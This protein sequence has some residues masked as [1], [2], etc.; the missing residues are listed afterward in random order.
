MQI[1][2]KLCA[3]MLLSATPV[4][5]ETPL[6]LHDAIASAVASNPALAHAT[7]V[8]DEA[9]SAQLADRGTYDPRLE[10][11]TLAHSER[12]QPRA[13]SPL[14]QLLA[15]DTIRSSVAIVK[16]DEDGSE[17]RVGIGIERDI[18][19]TRLVGNGT[20]QDFDQH[21][22][23]PRVEA[24]LREPLLGGRRTADAIRDRLA[25]DRDGAKLDREATAAQVLRDVE[26][27]YWQLYLAQQ[28]VSIRHDATTAG[29]SQL[30]QANAEIERGARPRL[31]AAE[32]EE[33]LARRREDELVATGAVG[34]RSLDL[35]RLLGI[36]PTSE[37][38]ASDRI[39]ELDA[40]KVTTETA[41]QLR[42]AEAR[43]RA[44]AASVVEADDRTRWQLDA[45]LT[46]SLST[47]RDRTR[48]AI[49][50]TAGYGGFVVELAVTLRVP[51]TDR[52]AEGARVAAHARYLE[53]GVARG[54]AAAELAT[55]VARWTNRRDVARQRRDALQ[56]ARELADQNLAAEQNRWERGDTTSYEVLR[57]QAA[58]GDARLRVERAKIDEID[59]DTALAAAT[60]ELL[61]RR[62]IRLR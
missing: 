16:T 37:L 42:A 12:A 28:E 58:V 62:G 59:A 38:R 45:T 48:A 47:P 18:E 41:P 53:A 2:I 34:E 30:R 61:A 60:G 40:P 57:R 23:T 20:H 39:G 8:L 35:A 14:T 32:I 44:A 36:V 43:T 24:K 3:L 50:A 25:A 1:Q 55:E 26:H 29:E 6:G 13:L 7:L 49:D 52:A 22:I 54:D 27:A 19:T 51:L 10:V 11:Q 46:G 56:R 21:T 4:R 15:N 31:A 33:E 5:A 9:E 17:L